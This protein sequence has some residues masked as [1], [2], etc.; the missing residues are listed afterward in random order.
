MIFSQALMIALLAL[1]PGIVAGIFVAYLISL[2]T[3]HVIGHTVAFNVHLDLMIG[4][5]VVGLFLI[6]AAAWFPADRAAKLNLQT[7]LS[8]R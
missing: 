6:A 3:V 5:F 1:L 7:A 8:F 2:S 4:S